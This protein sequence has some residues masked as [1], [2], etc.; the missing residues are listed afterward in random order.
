MSWLARSR[1][2]R[3]SRLG[4]EASFAGPHA[5]CIAS[6]TNVAT[7]A[8]PTMIFASL[9][10]SVIP[11]IEANMTNR[12]RS[13]TTIVYRRSHRSAT[14]PA[15]GPRMSAGSI[16]TATTDPNASPLAADPLTLFDAKIALA[17]R[18]SQSPIEDRP[19]TSHS[20]RNARIR[21][22]AFRLSNPDS[23][24]PACGGGGS[25]FDFLA[26]AVTSAYR[27]CLAPNVLTV[28]ALRIGGGHGAAGATVCERVSPF[29]GHPIR[30]RRA[31]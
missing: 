8:Q 17:S 28:A 1:R 10:S 27:P 18:P 29:P 11:G 9:V 14:T 24:T 19:R 13:E 21:H 12:V 2:A 30:C 22:S 16:R 26:M 15:S 3:G 7:V 5:I 4:T 25:P 23:S 6:M 20:R 31:T